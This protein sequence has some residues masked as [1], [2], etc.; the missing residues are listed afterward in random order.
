MNEPE[1]LLTTLQAARRLNVW[2]NSILRWI[3]AGKL[4]ATKTPGGQYRIAASA[5]HQIG[6]ARVLPGKLPD[7]SRTTPK[8]TTVVEP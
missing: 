5:L 8:A 7:S 4:S 6:T 3:K 2:P 1:E